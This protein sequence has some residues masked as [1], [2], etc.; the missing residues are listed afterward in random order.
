MRFAKRKLLSKF[1]IF[2]LNLLIIDNYG[3]KIEREIK[4]KIKKGI[5]LGLSQEEY[6]IHK[7]EY[8]HQYYQENKDR[9]FEQQ[10]EY[11]R[12]KKAGL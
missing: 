11:Y 4:T 2:K 8:Q 3:T 1:V 5:Y 12:K 6:K 7:K 10:K 9:I